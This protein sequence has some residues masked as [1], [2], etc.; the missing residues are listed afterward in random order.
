MKY[1]DIKFFS[2][3]CEE[4]PDHQSGMIT[5]KMIQQRLHEEIDELRAYIESQLAQ[6]EQE[7][8]AWM[9]EDGDVLSASVVSG[10]GLRNIPLYT[11][12]PQRKPLT[13]WQPIETAP[14]DGTEILMTNGV[15]VSSGQ[16]L[17][18]YGGTY[19]QEGA[20]NGDGC[21]A[22]WTDWS[23]GMQPDPTHWMPLPPPPIEPAHNIKE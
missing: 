5:N 7:P 6:P 14:R 4:H 13:G 2:E 17:S 12:P 23:G 22:G 8:V 20:P 15:D 21:D 9:D 11:T 16:W 10:K 19:D 1:E 18:E 3:R